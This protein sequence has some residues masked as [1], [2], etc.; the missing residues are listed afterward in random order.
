MKTIY[1][2]DSIIRSDYLQ[3][4]KDSIE[5]LGGAVGEGLRVKHH[6]ISFMK[7]LNDKNLIYL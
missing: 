2:F 3:I 1:W 5:S 4:Q 7:K 6:Y